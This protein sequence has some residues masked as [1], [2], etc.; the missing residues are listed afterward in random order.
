[1][2]IELIYYALLMM[3]VFFLSIQKKPVAISFFGIKL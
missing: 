3:I 1:M 2:K